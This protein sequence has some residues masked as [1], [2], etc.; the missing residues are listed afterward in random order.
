[1]NITVNIRH[2]E[3]HEVGL[4]GDA[5]PEEMGLQSLDELIRFQGAIRYDLVAQ[6]LEAAILVQG[7]VSLGLECEC[8]RC[9]NSFSSR[10]DILDWAVHLP[11]SGEEAVPV[12]NDCVDL[13][14]YICEDI[15]LALP[16]HPRCSQDCRGLVRENEGE[17]KASTDLV[18]DETRATWAGLDKLNL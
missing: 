18:P 12:E 17:A 16:Q 15:F 8:A 2:L 11:L 5:L 1:M 9:L 13:T 4:S 7:S 14:P 10:I 3:K 6:K